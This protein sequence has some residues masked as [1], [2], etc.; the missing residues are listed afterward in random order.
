MNINLT[1]MIISSNTYTIR[2]F[3]PIIAVTN[4]LFVAGVAPRR[5]VAAAGAAQTHSSAYLPTRPLHYH[6]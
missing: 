5:G 6:Y 1:V 3:T 2:V 4:K